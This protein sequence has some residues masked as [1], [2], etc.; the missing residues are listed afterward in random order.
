MRLDSVRRVPDPVG[1]LI[2]G[3]A[4]HADEAMPVLARTFVASRVGTAIDHDQLLDGRVLEAFENQRRLM[5][6]AVLATVLGV[7]VHQYRDLDG[8]Q[9]CVG[10][11]PGVA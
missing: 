9:V 8:G 10:T 7:V 6:L 4:L 3:F 2:D 5:G 1:D 11:A